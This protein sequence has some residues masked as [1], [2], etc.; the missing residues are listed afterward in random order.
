MVDTVLRDHHWFW[1][2]DTEQTIEPLE[3]LVS[4]YYQ[5]V[6]RNANLVLG[7]TPDPSGLVPEL[8]FKRCEEFGAEMRRRFARPAAPAPAGSSCP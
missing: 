1:K 5:S 4:F 7:L 6:G 2:P 3:K 8:D